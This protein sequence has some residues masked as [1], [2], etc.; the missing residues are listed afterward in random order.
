[1]KGNVLEN[2]NTFKDLGVIFDNH[3]IYDKHSEKSI[4]HIL[5]WGSLKD[6]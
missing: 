5:C 2:V 1:M 4:K 6:I 3:F